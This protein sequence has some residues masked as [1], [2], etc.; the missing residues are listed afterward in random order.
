[1]TPRRATGDVHLAVVGAGLIG[2]RHI[3]AIEAVRRTCL[4]AIIDPAPAA[5]KLAEEL[6]VWW[7]DSID[8]LAGRDGIDGV[9]LAT[10]NQLHE[11][12]ALACIAAGLPVL[13]EKPIAPTVAE[14]ERIAAAAQSSAVP[15]AVG[16]HRRHNPLVA[17]AK[18][19]VDGCEIGRIVS[20][21]AM[22]WMFKPDAYFEPGWRRAPGA[23][24]LLVNFVH[25]V[26]LLQHLCGPVRGVTA[27]A[28]NAVRGHDVEDTAA[29]V[30]EFESGALGT[31]NISDTIAAPWSWE[32]T[33]RENADYPPTSE[34]CYLVGGTHGALELPGMRLWRYDDTRSWTEPIGATQLH[35]ETGDPYVRQIG[36]FAEVIR[37]GARPL[38]CAEDGLAALRVVEAVKR[39]ASTGKRVSLSP[40]AGPRA[41]QQDHVYAADTARTSEGAGQRERDGSAA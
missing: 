10:P 1:M 3:A 20:V 22:V 14:A 30:L 16:H 6:G 9:V 13:I 11:E 7:S 40:G 4:A 19:L 2:R 24:P 23:G 39:S 18:A 35:V 26:D 8:A 41:A 37:D 17:R 15:V 28:S 12:G 27:N 21:N 25:D 29:V 5:A 38:V 33:A 36:Q 31:V 32:L 34:A